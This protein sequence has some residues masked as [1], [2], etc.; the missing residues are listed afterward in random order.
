MD[1]ADVPTTWR[2]ISRSSRVSKVRDDELAESIV[3]VVE[4]GE[5]PPFG[6]SVIRSDAVGEPPGWRAVEG[7]EP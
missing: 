3:V 5:D 4:R 7:R 2:S 6:E 1:Q